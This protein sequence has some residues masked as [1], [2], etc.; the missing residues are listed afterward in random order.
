MWTLDT[1]GG[2]IILFLPGM[3]MVTRGNDGTA[4]DHCLDTKDGCRVF[5]TSIDDSS[6]SAFLQC[7]VSGGRRRAP[8]RTPAD[9]S[10]VTE[11]AH[12]LD[13]EG[14]RTIRVPRGTRNIGKRR[15]EEAAAWL[16]SPR[17][18]MGRILRTFVAVTCVYQFP[19][20]GKP[21]VFNNN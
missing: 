5:S 11:E 2:T 9:R 4:P 14:L 15:E 18:S 8:R 12:P 17:E 7:L 21:I 19:R 10:C 16:A 20:S 1:F 6:F 3:I 13:I